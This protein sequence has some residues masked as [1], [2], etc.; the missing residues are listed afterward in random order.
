MEILA[1]KELYYRA[2]SFREKHSKISDII[3]GTMQKS[4]NTKEDG[5]KLLA[6]ETREMIS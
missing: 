1:C 3:E 2:L 4:L 5:P 6:L